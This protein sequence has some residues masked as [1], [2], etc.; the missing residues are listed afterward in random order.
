MLLD[1]EEE[2][3]RKKQEKRKKTRKKETTRPVMSII[4]WNGIMNEALRKYMMF[5]NM[6]LFFQCL[7]PLQSKISVFY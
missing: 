6:L 3:E 4:P 1:G 5:E 7:E 2:E